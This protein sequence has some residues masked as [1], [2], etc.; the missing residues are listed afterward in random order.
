MFS[1]YLSNNFFYPTDNVDP[2]PVDLIKAVVAKELL[3]RGEMKVLVVVRKVLPN[4]I[5]ITMMKS[6]T[7]KGFET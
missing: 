2:L 3:V 4:N 6:K 7:L 1:F 5:I